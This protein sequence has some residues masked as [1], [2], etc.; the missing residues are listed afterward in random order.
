[1][2]GVAAAAS[3]GFGERSLQQL[4]GIEPG[5]GRGRQQHGGRIGERGHEHRLGL[6]R[7]AL[8]ERAQILQDCRGEPLR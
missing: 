7:E 1:M 8:R 5:I 6:R 4:A 2:R 3:A